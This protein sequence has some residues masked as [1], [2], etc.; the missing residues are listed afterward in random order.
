LMMF[1]AINKR[2]LRLV[3]AALLMAAI[4]T[5]LLWAFRSTAVWD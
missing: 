2:T 1:A 4:F 5:A 3:G